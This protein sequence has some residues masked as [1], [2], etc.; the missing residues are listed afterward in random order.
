MT[1]NFPAGVFLL[2]TATTSIPDAQRPQL[3][4]P[5]PPDIFTVFLGGNRARYERVILAVCDGLCRSE[6]LC[7]TEA[8]VVGVIYDCIAREPGLWAEDEAASRK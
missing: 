1:A 7:P 3:F 6:L 2:G 4:A 5:M 8:E